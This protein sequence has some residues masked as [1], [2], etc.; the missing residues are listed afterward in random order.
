MTDASQI[1]DTDKFAIVV[2]FAV[3]TDLTVVT[4]N[5]ISL[6][7]GDIPTRPAP[8]TTDQ[9]LRE[10]QYYYEK[11]YAAGTAVGTATTINQYSAQQRI[12]ITGGTD[13][14]VAGAF[15]IPYKATKRA[16][17]SVKFYS[18]SGT[19]DSFTAA[20]YQNGAYAS[21]G[22]SVGIGNWSPTA[23][24]AAI[25]VDSLTYAADGVSSLGASASGNAPEG[26]IFGH[27]VL[28]SRL[29]I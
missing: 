29:G 23:V 11:S 6:V 5:S 21:V 19:A 20:L 13:R 15:F 24:G 14:V 1:S 4:V 7:P 22:G 12:Y 18:T 27:Y 17:P 16:V 9:V 26:V 25:G 8:Q 28:D 10:C 2:T 3:P